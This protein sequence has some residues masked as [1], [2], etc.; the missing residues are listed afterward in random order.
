MDEQT[1][2]EY[3]QDLGIELK[4]LDLIKENKYC[5]IYLADTPDGARIV[6]KYKTG[7]PSLVRIEAEAL[8]FYHLLAQDDANLID[9]GEPLLREDKKLICIGFVEGEAFSDVLVRSRKDSDLRKRCVQ[10]M[11]I[12][13]KIIRTI[14]DRTQSQEATSPF[15]FEYFDYCSARLEKIPI[16]GP[17]FFN[18]LSSE[19][20]ELADEFRGSNDVPSFVHGDFVFKNIHVMDDR[21]GLIDFANANSCSHPLND[22]YNLRFA[23]A[24]MLLPKR[25]KEDLLASFYEGLGSVEFSDIAHRFY[26]EYHRRRWLMLKLMSGSLSDLAQGFRGLASFAKPFDARI[27]A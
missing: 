11:R 2:I 13:G 24:N 14:Y 10:W 6:K 4:S 7:D 21:V 22:I 19:A 16:F 9:S 12:L 18:G 1:C 8:R 25:F 27:T 17:I 5:A 23:L 26:Y 15:I 20:R 3:S